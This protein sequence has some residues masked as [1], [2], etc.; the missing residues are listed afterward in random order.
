MKVKELIEAL[1]KCNPEQLVVFTGNE[2]AIS[3][4][5][6][7]HDIQIALNVNNEWWQGPHVAVVTDFQKEMYPAHMYSY[8]DAILVG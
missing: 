1:Q 6:A 3:E 4:V 5:S 7:L 8:A 2:G